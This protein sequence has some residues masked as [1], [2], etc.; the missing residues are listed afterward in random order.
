MRILLVKPRARLATIRGLQRFTFL[1]PLE[2]AYLAAAAGPA[3]DVR[4]LDLRLTRWPRRA[5]ARAMREHQ[6][7]VVG[8]SAYSH[9]GSTVKELAGLV[10]T[11]LPKAFVVV[12]GHHATVAPADLNVPQVDAIVRGEGCRPLGAILAALAKREEVGGIP[13]VLQTGVGFDDEAARTWPSFPDPATLPRPRRDLYD[14]RTYYSV[15]LAARLPSWGRL[16]PPTALVRA[17]F[18]CT[19]KCTF[20]I[21]PY[22][23]GGK[24]LPRPAEDVADEIA[25]LPQH[26]V[27]FADDE[28]FLNEGF[29]FE[30]A[31]ALERRRVRKRY[32][33]WARA[34]TVLRSP[35]LMKRWAGLGLDAAFM[36]YEHP[37]DE[38]LRSSRKGATVAVN[39]RSLDL[40][41]SLGVAVHASWLLRPEYTEEDFDRL[42]RYVTGLPPAEHSFNVVTPS[43]GTPDYAAIEP[44]I[45]VPN[46]HDLHDAMH[47]LTRTALPLKQFAARYAELVVKGIRVSPLRSTRR[48]TRPDDLARA[49]WSEQ[50]Y[51]RA[52]RN[53]HRDYPEELWR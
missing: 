21:V 7:E 53:L 15:W 46:P 11:A 9:E 6:P 41:S 10:R 3:H 36:G 48:P 35:E 39:E 16:F 26:N 22:L 4:I 42:K 43:P 37:T 17:S 19:Q 2:L 34:T 23:C 47:P 8:F 32:F 27:Y 29:A 1:E 30:L 50:L 28:N 45:W 13:D 44:S 40:F 38:E 25:A 31:E 24:H 49:L 18:G 5:L 12:G 14:W 33:V 51:Y 20:C 52:Y